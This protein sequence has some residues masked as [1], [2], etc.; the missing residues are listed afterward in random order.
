MQHVEFIRGIFSLMVLSCIVKKLAFTS[1]GG[2]RFD[3]EISAIKVV[4]AG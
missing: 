1:I 3:E 4:N 2:Y